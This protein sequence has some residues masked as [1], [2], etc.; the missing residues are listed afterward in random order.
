MM[1]DLQED[2]CHNINFVSPSH[3]VAQILAGVAIAAR[4]GLRLP[5]VYN[6]GGYDSLVALRLLAGVI[7]ICMPDL[8]YADPHVALHLSKAKE[9]PFINQRAV[10]EMHR[11]VGD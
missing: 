7:D 6:S 3:V 1:L 5:L 4:K 9:Y 8:K 11:Q 2:G 10:K